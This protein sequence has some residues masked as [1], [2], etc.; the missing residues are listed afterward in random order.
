MEPIADLTSDKNAVDTISVL[1]KELSE[2]T[3]KN[4][5]LVAYGGS[6][7]ADLNDDKNVTD[8]IAALE[9]EISEKTGKK[10]ILVAFSL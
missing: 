10:V 6:K 1:E 9:K 5:L 3:G 8:K 4:V 2:K 7:Y